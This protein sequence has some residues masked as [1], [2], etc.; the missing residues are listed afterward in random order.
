MIV[1]EQL[2]RGYCTRKSSLPHFR[3]KNTE[4]ISPVTRPLSFL[5]SPVDHTG[6]NITRNINLLERCVWAES[7]TKNRQ[8][9]RPADNGQATNRPL[10]LFA[11]QLLSETL[12]VEGRGTERGRKSG[13]TRGDR[14]GAEG[15]T[16]RSDL[17]RKCDTRA[18]TTP[19]S[20]TSEIL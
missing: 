4:H 19:P 14:P 16:A 2:L 3:H 20:I 5:S 8:R 7:E 10:F 13:R 18:L 15:I 12:L 6:H 1:G 9:Q 17:K 11:K